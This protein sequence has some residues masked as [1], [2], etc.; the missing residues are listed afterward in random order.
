M[1]RLSLLSS[2]LVLAVTFFTFSCKQQ[3]ETPNPTNQN[4]ITP[5]L[6]A[7][8]KKLGFDPEGTRRSVF[9]N[10]F[11][12]E[13]SEGYLVEGDMFISKDELKSMAASE[14]KVG[15][16]GEQYR[17]N[18]LVQRLP[19]TLRIVGYT[20]GTRTINV[21]LDEDAD[22]VRDGRATVRALSNRMRTGVRWAINNYNRLNIGLNFNLTF[23]GNTNNAD[24]VI[25]QEV[26]GGA[27][28]IARFPSGGNPGNTVRLFDGLNNFSNNVN[29]H[30]ATHEIGH[31]LGFRHTDFFNRS[32]SCGR[33]GNEGNGGVGA[34]HI[35]GTGTTN[36][37]GGFDFDSIML[38]CFNNGVDGE[39]SNQDIRALE[40]LY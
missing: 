21:A 35:P 14:V 9:T 3:G 27:G 29:E 5:E 23:S 4:S 2:L 34:V 12:N 11:T 17:T 19:R 36:N 39:F 13:K 16:N 37:A 40:F 30:V 25:Y 20:G 38:A 31:C 32:I 8:L 1:K 18:S 26:I 28:G 33:P 15:P 10:P 7:Q 6:K 24:I 22:N